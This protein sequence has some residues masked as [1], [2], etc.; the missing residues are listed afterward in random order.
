[1]ERAGPP[2]QL[3]FGAGQKRKTTDQTTDRRIQPARCRNQQN[4]NPVPENN[5][6][7]P[8][9]DVE[10]IQVP[11]TDP[12]ESDRYYVAWD[13]SFQEHITIDNRQLRGCNKHRASLSGV[14][15]GSMEYMS[16]ANLFMMLSPKIIMKL[17]FS[18][19]LTES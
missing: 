4:D 18:Q 8:E 13:E 7:D 5:E 2:N 17:T 11:P 10:S 6:S 14:S 12:N 15:T 9:S 3:F 1:M 16:A 19:P